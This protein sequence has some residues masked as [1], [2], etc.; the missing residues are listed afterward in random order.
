MYKY[1]IP[2]LEVIKEDDVPKQVHFRIAC[3]LLDKNSK[4]IKHSTHEEKINIE[5]M[6]LASV[7]VENVK[8]WIKT[9]M[10]APGPSKI[11]D[12]QAKVDAIVETPP[13]ITTE[14][15]KGGEL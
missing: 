15:Y 14:E 7:T 8:A 4:P 1:S 10:T 13:V 12:L 9:Y 11:D 6:D 3:E 5:E 2:L